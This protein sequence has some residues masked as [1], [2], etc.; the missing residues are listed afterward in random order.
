MARQYINE[1]YP[2]FLHGADYNPEQ[3][4]ATPEIW[5]A[6]RRLMQEANCNEMSVGIFSWAMLEPREGEYDFSFL[7]T[8]L[9]KVYAAGGRVVLATPSGAR[10]RWMAEKYP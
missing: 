9:D 4:T 8:I 3:W 7:D 2:H 5:D 6:D 10:P 1:K